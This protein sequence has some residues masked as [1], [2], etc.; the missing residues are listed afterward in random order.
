MPLSSGGFSSCG[1]C[2]ARQ[3]K[4]HQESMETMMLLVSTTPAER[5]TMSFFDQSLKSRGPSGE[6][7]EISGTDTIAAK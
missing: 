5:S 1:R 3:E 7:E 2:L 4:N 6:D